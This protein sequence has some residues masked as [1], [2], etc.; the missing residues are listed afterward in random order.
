M[1]SWL[2]ILFS[3]CCCS[4]N[5]YRNVL[6][7]GLS[8]NYSIVCYI[9]SINWS[10]NY[11]LSDNWSLNNFLF[12]NWL[13]NHFFFNNWLWNNS[14]SNNWFRNNFL[15]LCNNWFSVKNL[16]II[17]LCGFECLWEFVR[18]FNCISV[19]RTLN[20]RKLSRLNQSS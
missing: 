13:R 8:I 2:D 16:S 5:I 15:S 12:N 11:F 19:T 18:S 14:F 1:N 17:I 3:N 4:R 9:F 20:F 6:S 7:N 10:F